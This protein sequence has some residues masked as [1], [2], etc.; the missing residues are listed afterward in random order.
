MPHDLH[1]TALKLDD[2]MTTK[3]GQTAYQ[4][5]SNYPDSCHRRLWRP[6]FARSPLTMLAMASNPCDK[7]PRPWPTEPIPTLCGS[8]RARLALDSSAT[9]GAGLGTVRT[10]AKT[11]PIH[12]VCI[13][14]PACPSLLVRFESA[15]ASFHRSHVSMSN[16]ASC[17]E[18][19][20]ASTP[21]LR[22]VR[23]GKP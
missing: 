17:L 13:A 23:I 6:G 8:E 21:W 16:S 15:E 20:D 10:Y 14:F 5:Q 7:P 18:K 3:L 1:T 11:V 12:W 4:G 22:L 2:W 19:P 9:K